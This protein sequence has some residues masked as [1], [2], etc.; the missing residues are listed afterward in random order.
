VRPAD[1]HIDD[2]PELHIIIG[3]QL[4]LIFFFIEVNHHM[5]ILEIETVGDFFGYNINGIVQHLGIYLADD[6]E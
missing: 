4:D 2:L 1:E 3:F 6:I 5:G